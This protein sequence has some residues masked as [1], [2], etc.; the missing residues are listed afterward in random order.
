MFHWIFL[1]L[2]SL[3]EHGSRPWWKETPL[4]GNC[5]ILMLQLHKNVLLVTNNPLQCCICPFL[6][7][8]Q[9]C[10]SALV[11]L[12]LCGDITHTHVYKFNVATMWREN[13]V[14]LLWPV[15]VWLCFHMSKNQFRFFSHEMCFSFIL[16]F[17]FRFAVSPVDLYE[18]F[19]LYCSQKAMKLLN[20]LCIK[21]V[22]HFY[23]VWIT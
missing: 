15:P 18:P 6:C 8:Y 14:F 3:C 4:Q 23:P 16:I 5:S 9:P 21:T 2:Y 19:P 11:S 7:H 13:G 22:D 12:C 17:L 20:I 10:A 1:Y